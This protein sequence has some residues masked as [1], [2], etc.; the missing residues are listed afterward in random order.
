M[1][2][3]ELTKIPRPLKKILNV[4]FNFVLKSLVNLKLKLKNSI[5]ELVESDSI[6]I[7]Q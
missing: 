4:D 7:S 5:S 1:N 3:R 2:C 6:T